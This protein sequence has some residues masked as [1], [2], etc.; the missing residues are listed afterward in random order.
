MKTRAITREVGTS[1]ADC[2]LT[3][4]ERE[5]IDVEKAKAQHAAYDEALR[6]A[7][8]EVEV[9]PADDE[10]PD[11]VFVE[12]TAVVF[13]E[14]AVITRPGTPER[15]R[16]VPAVEAAL[17]RYRELRR[18][19]APGT[20]EGGDVLRVGRAYYVGVTSRTNREGFEQFASIVR[21][22]GY[23]AIPVGVSGCLHLKSAVTAL[24]EETLLLNPSWLDAAAL[25]NVR[26]VVVPAE[27]PFGANSLV[28]NGVVHL[29][30]RW[31]R[32]RELVE[33]AGFPVTPL[34]VSEFEK[35]EAGLTCLSLIFSAQ[36]PTL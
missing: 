34:D 33:K 27:E 20:L 9:L 5:P 16:E 2:L 30:A 4:L 19:T 32:T 15:Q 12:D 7:G 6:R 13:D 31:K 1:L 8:A 36:R 25:P 18:I 14:A 17:S 10:L 11:S 22:F 23:R 21:E 29:S 24:D 35:A 26:R 3:F 28:A